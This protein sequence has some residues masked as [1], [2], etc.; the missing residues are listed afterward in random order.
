MR[1]TVG[2]NHQVPPHPSPDSPLSG[3][4]DVRDALLRRGELLDLDHRSETQGAELKSLTASLKAT[5][6]DGG[7][8]LRL[9][10]IADAALLEWLGSREPVNPLSGPI[11]LADRT[12]SDRR[13]FAWTHPQLVASEWQGS[14][15]TNVVWVA[16]SLGL[17]DRL[18]EI[19][20]PAA[21]TLDPEQADTAVFYSIWN[22]EAVLSGLGRG[23]D[24]IVGT[25]AQLQAEL[26][27]LRTFVT[28]S[29]IP[30]F[31]KWVQSEHPD[32]GPDHPL[33]RELCAEYLTSFGTRARLIDPVA[34][35]HMGNGARLLRIVAE[36]DPS[37]SGQDRSFALMANYRYGPEDLSANAE[38]LANGQ[39]ALGAEVSA[40][41]P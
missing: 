11:D 24:L 27:A 26:P 39:P 31:R 25:K 5:L 22:T 15:P 38:S 21:P 17:P 1:S 9:D 13:V 32:V 18:A 4:G 23:R 19:L 40:L 36:A 34:R 37:P 10:P 29:P 7:E 6:S 41:L 12:D 14:R 16:L 8:A 28:M 20:D 2:Q 35:F 30:G 3:P 33:L